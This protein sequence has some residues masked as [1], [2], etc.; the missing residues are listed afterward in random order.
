MHVVIGVLK[1]VNVNNKIYQQW[2]I[3]NESECSQLPD[4]A[5]TGAQIQMLTTGIA[6]L[7]TA[8]CFYV[9]G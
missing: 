6:H 7:L 5:V 4:R 1:S 2:S 9:C 3:A 8:T